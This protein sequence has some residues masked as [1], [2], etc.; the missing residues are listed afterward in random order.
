MG[1]WLRRQI[2]RLLDNESANGVP[3]STK[4]I[5]HHLE[6][7]FLDEEVYVLH[8]RTSETVHS[9]IFVINPSET[10][11]RNYYILLTSGMSALPMN[12]PAD[13]NEFR[14]GELMMLLPSSWN[15]SHE[16]FDDEDNWWPIRLLIE[17]TKYPHEED[18]WLGYGHTFA[19]QNEGIFSTGTGFSAA[20]L[21]ESVTVPEP[22]LKIRRMFNRH[23][24]ILSV[25]PIYPEELAYKLAHGTNALL[26]RFEEHGIEEVVDNERINT[27]K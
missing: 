24:H 26:E 10:A 19:R 12:T 6:K 25:I 4:I 16:S 17:M 9:D 18:T 22:F 1:D 7:F 8:E 13:Y 15:M 2:D 5:D 11:D 20:V 21:L 14:Y 3:S 23:I 27:C